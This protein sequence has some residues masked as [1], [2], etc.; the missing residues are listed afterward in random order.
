MQYFRS[1]MLK[2]V[3]LHRIVPIRGLKTTGTYYNIVRR[4]ASLQVIVSL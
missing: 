3:P 2:K 1:K 4:D